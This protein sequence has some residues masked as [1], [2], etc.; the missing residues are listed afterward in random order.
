MHEI[1]PKIP[2]TQ[3]SRHFCQACV[4]APMRRPGA[5]VGAVKNAKPAVRKGAPS[6][7]RFATAPGERVSERSKLGLGAGL[8][9]AAIVGLSL[10]ALSAVPLR[11]A[12]T[13]QQGAAEQR[14]PR[15]AMPVVREDAP[16]LAPVSVEVDGRRLIATVVAAKPRFARPDPQA[17]CDLIAGRAG[18]APWAESAL[19]PG[20]WECLT[21]SGDAIASA[22]AVHEPIFAIARGKSPGTI[23]TIRVKLSLSEDDEAKEGRKRLQ[24]MATALMQAAGQTMP[25]PILQSL[26]TLEPAKAASD[27]ADFTFAPEKMFP[28]RYNLIIKFKSQEAG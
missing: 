14:P 20:A 1:G 23:D 2:E 7:R 24:E 6:R 15:M 11:S 4:H 9:L 18:G 21:D 19:R 22:A 28:G 26:E 3:F 5:R 17:L 12:V 25:D 16:A 10:A 27:R 13:P 8:R